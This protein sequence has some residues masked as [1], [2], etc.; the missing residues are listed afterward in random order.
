MHTP[1]FCQCL[2]TL[3]RDLS[4]CCRHIAGVCCMS[5]GYTGQQWDVHICAFYRTLSPHHCLTSVSATNAQTSQ[6]FIVLTPQQPVARRLIFHRSCGHFWPSFALRKCCVIINVT[7]SASLFLH[8]CLFIIHKNWLYFSSEQW[9]NIWRQA[10]WCEITLN[11][12]WQCTLP[13][14]FQKRLKRRKVSTQ[15]VNNQ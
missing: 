5:T 14:S 9:L 3:Q 1:I 11:F 15:S 7:L 8:A 12:V 13:L 10:T 2:P 6:R 4:S